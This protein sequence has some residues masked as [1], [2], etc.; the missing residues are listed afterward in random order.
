V[1]QV[2]VV[3][4]A[5]AGMNSALTLCATDAAVDLFTQ[6]GGTP[7]AG[8]TWSAPGGGA[9]GGVFDPAAS[10]PG[11]YTYT[12]A[13]IA[14]CLGASATVTVTTI[15]APQAG[16]SAAQTLCSTSAPLD[17]YST[18]GGTPDPAGAWTAPGGAAFGGVF[19]P[20]VHAAGTYT[21]TVSGTPPC[22]AASA[23]VAIGVE[24]QPLAGNG[25][26]ISVCGDAAPF[27]LFG[28]LGGTPTSGGTWTG[29]SGAL[30]N[31]IYDP[32][33]GNG[34]VFT[35]AVVASAPC[36]TATA[37]VTITQEAPVTAGSDAAVSLCVLDAPVALI[38][39]LGGAPQSG[40]IWTGPSG[41]QV[42]SAID[43]ATAQ[44]GAYTYTV[45]GT[46]PCTD[47]SAVLL[48]TV[49]PAPNAGADAQVAL[50]TT[51]SALQLITLLG[52]SPM[53]GGTWTNASGAPQPATF[54]PAGNSAGPYTFTY[55]VP[56]TAPCAAA[57][58]VLDLLL[59]GAPQAGQGGMLTLCLNAAPA[60][61]FDG[62][63][64]TLDAGGTWTGPDG[65]PH[66][67]V[68][69][70]ALDL[71]GSYTYTVGGGVA[72]PAATAAV[73]VV[74]LPTP[75]AGTDTAVALCTS[76]APV[77][78]LALLGGSPD[79]GG[80]WSGPDGAPV[81]ALFSP[82]SGA[83][84]A[85]TYTVAG[86]PPCLPDQA[87]VSIALVQAAQAGTN[88]SATLCP[89]DP[90]VALANLLGGAPD[91]GGVWTGPTGAV[92]GGTMDPAMA[93]S[94]TYTYTVVPPAPCPAVSASLLLTVVPPPNAMPSA[95]P[96]DGCLPAV[97]V[98]N[99]GYNGSG[100][101]T[102]TL[103]PGISFE[104]CGATAI[105]LAEPGT[106]QPV[107]TIDP[108]SG[109][110]VLSYTLQPF[111]L[112]LPPVADFT[113]TPEALN[114]LAAQVYLSSTSIGAD[115]LTWTIDG[116]I[117]STAPAAW[118]QFSDVLGMDHEVC[119]V[120]VAGNGCPDTLC[121]TIT[122]GD[123]PL[124]YVPNAFTPD[125]DGI[126]DTFRPVVSNIDPG[127]YLLEIFDRW[128][129]VVHRSSDPTAA[130][131]GRSAGEEVP[132]G[133]YVWTLRVSDPLTRR[134]FRERGHVEL[135]R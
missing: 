44:D 128:G 9:S 62:L 26:A 117:I 78:L 79:P 96:G 123:G 42:G 67:S 114:V 51:E 120:A 109:C 125:G 30:P 64:G 24:Q 31:G 119:L 60:S 5:N 103:A 106:W 11:V 43:P 57:T 1:V 129:R 73:N 121:R 87:V 45:Q 94:G 36:T 13:P 18:L 34:G 58:A 122:V 81:A 110:P 46:A 124:V 37:T 59:E 41:S 47:A 21:Y 126:N 20:A 71:P 134:Q 83:P 50:C 70:P 115:A 29:P 68:I 133:T 80:A 93:V 131:D 35:Y 56:G 82:L 95:D 23:T 112:V 75:V 107:L 3:G 28:L 113:Y 90:P 19:D 77:D 118:H 10:T 100:T 7:D 61:L 91:P 12:I 27:G 99:S 69:D 6:L 33:T 38:S 25:A 98:L 89:G 111:T 127:S 76:D 66:A 101:C 55:T 39:L 116:T 17:L 15:S 2:S 108:G 48:L 63:S 53:P 22:A 52:G 54:D 105:T 97:V 8:G 104:A 74:L 135:V 84:G 88:G 85:Y 49:V 16:L 102:W 32:A 132:I 130:W 86:T 40:G 14:P 72:C 4:D 92:V 65:A